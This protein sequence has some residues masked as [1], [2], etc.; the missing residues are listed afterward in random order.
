[1][2]LDD[3]PDIAISSISNQQL[4]MYIGRCKAVLPLQCTADNNITVECLVPLR[5]AMVPHPFQQKY[6]IVSSATDDSA[7]LAAL[8]L[9]LV[10]DCLLDSDRELLRDACSR[11]PWTVTREE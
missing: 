9:G 10:R 7:P 8:Q 11:P 2:P 6:I 3:I 4:A 5:Q 1:M